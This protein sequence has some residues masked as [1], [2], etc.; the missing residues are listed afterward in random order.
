MHL[1]VRSCDSTCKYE[2]MIAP[3]TNYALSHTLTHSHQ[4]LAD[5]LFDTSF[6]KKKNNNEAVIQEPT[7][8]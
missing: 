2:C 5:L 1:S 3:K 8:Y 4:I 7:I 6:A